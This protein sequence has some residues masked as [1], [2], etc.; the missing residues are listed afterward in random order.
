MKFII[1]L[2]ILWFTPHC[3]VAAQQFYFQILITEFMADPVPVVGLPNAEYIELYNNSSDTIQLLNWQIAD[4]AGSATI[5]TPYAF[6]PYSYLIVCSNSH[7]P[8]FIPYGNTLGISSFPNLNNDADDITIIHPSGIIVHQLSYN[9]KWYKDLYKQNGGFSIEMID[10]TLP[11]AGILNYRASEDPTGGTPGRPN[12]VQQQL[13]DTTLPAI[14]TGFLADEDQAIIFFSKPVHPGIALS[15]ISVS[16]N[17][18]FTATAINLLTPY[19][20]KLSFNTYLSH[21]EQYLLQI[22]HV[23]DCSGNSRSD[24]Q[25]LS[26][27]FIS[28]PESKDIIFN[29]WMIHPSA[30]GIEYIEIYNNSSRIINLKDILIAQLNSSNAYQFIQAFSDQSYPIYPKEYKVV[31]SDAGILLSLYPLS[32]QQIIEIPRLPALH[33]QSAH[34]LILYKD[35]SVIED[36]TY[37]SSWHHTVHTNLQGIALERIHPFLPSDSDDNW[38]SA[39]A[40]SGYATPGMPNSQ[41]YIHPF[42]SNPSVWK[43]SPYVSPDGDGINDLL[44]IEYNLPYPQF[45][46]NLYIYNLSGRLL[47]IAYSNFTL[48][49]SGI[50]LW[51]GF[52]RWRAY[53]NRGIYIVVAILHHQNGQYRKF[54]SPVVVYY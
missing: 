32:P 43:V 12:S 39:A 46:L 17:Q 50:L 26:I 36:I 4:A 47:T 27:G 37:H 49:K 14:T 7:V 19:S 29:E 40:S 18:R 20:I 1:L 34:W 10:H 3:F 13:T 9:L 48:T 16:L 22:Q 52:E 38:T 35:G 51:K 41:S 31:S 42:T 15:E 33:N 25:E 8:L 54:K 24:V 2:I 30:N 44:I 6:P 53:A 21:Q 28:T 45:I 23:Y 11:C 5:R